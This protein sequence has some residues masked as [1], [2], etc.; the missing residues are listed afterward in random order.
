[1]PALTPLPQA[2]TVKGYLDMGLPVARVAEITSVPYGTV[3]QIKDEAGPWSELT[4]EPVFSEFRH[5]AKQQAR[6]GFLQITRKA[7]QKTYEKLDDEKLSAFQ[8]VTIA[9]ISVDKE[10][11]LA[12]EV[13]QHIEIKSHIQ[14]EGLDKLASALSQLL[15]ARQGQ[16]IDITSKSEEQKS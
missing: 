15:L 10:R 11:L 6:A 5:I 4:E 14:V 13:T 1:M 2:G 8:A 16:A 9:A 3:R 12:G 7:I